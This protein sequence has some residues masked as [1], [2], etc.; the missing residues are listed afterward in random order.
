MKAILHRITDAHPTRVSAELKE[1][2]L[3]VHL[4][5][6]EKARHQQIEITVF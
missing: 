3:T 2:V 1:G 4:A 6:D 5:K